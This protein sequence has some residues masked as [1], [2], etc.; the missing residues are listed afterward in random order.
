MS[1]SREP[2]VI[3]SPF[4]SL[5]D[6]FYKAKEDSADF[7]AVIIQNPHGQ[8]GFGFVI[9]RNEID[10]E[11]FAISSFEF[12]AL[13]EAREYLEAQL[14]YVVIDPHQTRFQSKLSQ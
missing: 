11:D 3:D 9:R 8:G 1:H 2:Y 14:L 10:A 6:T 4:E 12:G 7:H 13:S 5:H